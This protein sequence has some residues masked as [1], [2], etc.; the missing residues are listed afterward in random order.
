VYECEMRSVSSKCTV[1]TLISP[2][3]DN[4]DDV[5]VLQIWVIGKEQLL[6]D[7]ITSHQNIWSRRQESV[8]ALQER[9]AVDGL[10]DSCC[11]L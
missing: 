6:A 10:L 9:S 11:L 2:L 1:L 7:L 3:I 4:R 5:R 8:R